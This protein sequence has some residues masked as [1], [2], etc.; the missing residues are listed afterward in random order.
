MELSGRSESVK[1]NLEKHPNGCF[2]VIYLLKIMD[3]H[4]IH[5]NFDYSINAYIDNISFLK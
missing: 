5:D 1:S 3:K 4:N 2:L